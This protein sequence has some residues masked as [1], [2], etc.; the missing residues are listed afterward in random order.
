[1]TINTQDNICP[2]CHIRTKLFETFKKCLYCSKK[3]CNQCWSE[4]QISDDYKILNDTLP[5]VDSTN[6]RRICP[7]CI[8]RLLQGNFKLKKQIDYIDTNDDNYQLALAISL[9]QSEADE[10]M[11]QKRKFDE[12]KDIRIETKLNDNKENLVEKTAEA[13]ERFMNRAKSNCELKSGR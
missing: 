3:H 10:K 13:I 5:K 6:L 9:S 2:R 7:T 8:K 11:K 4:F 1:M 12:D